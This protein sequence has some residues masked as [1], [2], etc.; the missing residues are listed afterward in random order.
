MP[1]A[2]TPQALPMG[3]FLVDELGRLGLEHDRVGGFAFRWRGR[4]M[5]LEIV[6]E[7]LSHQL[8]AALA[9]ECRL[10]LSARIGRIPS[11]ALAPERRPDAFALLRFLPTQ[12]P[13]GW[14]LS[15]LADHGLRVAA[16]YH[17]ALPAVVGELLVPATR[18]SLE[19]APYLDVLE[20]YGVAMEA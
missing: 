8:P 19:L 4:P 3:A 1:P 7:T 20:E 15:L 13:E 6:P 11:T 10:R 16:E 2:G 5:T 17:L 18:F 9:G 14:T 12:L